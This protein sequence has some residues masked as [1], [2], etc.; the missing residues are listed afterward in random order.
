MLIEQMPIW[1]HH[2]LTVKKRRKS[3]EILS[4]AICHWEH[5]PR[6]SSEACIPHCLS[7]VPYRSWIGR[8]GL[9][10]RKQ[11][12]AMS[13]ETWRRPAP[14]ISIV[15]LWGHRY[16]RA[17]TE[18]RFSQ[19]SEALFQ[20]VQAQETLEYHILKRVHGLPS[21]TSLFLEC[22][23]LSTQE[24]PDYSTRITLNHLSFGSVPD[25][26]LVTLLRE[27]AIAHSVASCTFVIVHTTCCFPI[28]CWFL[29]A[30]IGCKLQKWKDHTTPCLLCIL[31]A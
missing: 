13:P 29:C 11:T 8:P 28:I 25:S 3:W 26:H 19:P 30:P 6:S 18:H 22:C 23:S 2:P 20:D 1:N 27:F 17:F 7:F 10:Y 16:W 4:L 31:S 21:H 12:V 14:D 5:R 9:R 24:V 15:L